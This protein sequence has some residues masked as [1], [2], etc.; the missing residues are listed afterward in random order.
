MLHISL[1][2][3][4]KIKKE[5]LRKQTVIKNKKYR[6]IHFDD[7]STLMDL[8]VTWQS[9]WPSQVSSSINEEFESFQDASKGLRARHRFDVARLRKFKEVTSR[10]LNQYNL[11]YH[12]NFFN[13]FCFTKRFN[14]SL[15]D[16]AYKLFFNFRT[17]RLFINLISP[18]GRNY[19]SLAS[20]PLLKFFANRK[21]LKKSKT[22]KMLLVK[23]LRKL[24]IVAD[25]S[26]L[27]IIFKG[28]I[29]SLSEITNTLLSP[30]PSPFFDPIK[31]VTVS[32]VDNLPHRLTITYVLF[33]NIKSFTNMKHRSKGRLKRKIYRRVVKSNR[34]TD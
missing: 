18:S 28:R 22:F 17:N 1:K 19:L 25:I 7:Q 20:G 15:V 14:S 5:N 3:L 6:S 34:I 8:A 9:F 10:F 21:A 30:L 29:S 33:D 4:N 12:R 23:F 31:G 26:T 16:N 27:R 32:E 11:F 24:L 13:L 2:S